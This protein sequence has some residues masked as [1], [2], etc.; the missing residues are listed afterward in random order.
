[1]GNNKLQRIRGRA[2]HPVWL[3]L[4]R[5]GTIGRCLAPLLLTL[6]ITASLPS[7]TPAPLTFAGSAAPLVPLKPPPEGTSIV[8][9]TYRCLHVRSVSLQAALVASFEPDMLHVIVGPEANNPKLESQ[10]N[11]AGGSDVKALATS[12]LTADPGHFAKDLILVGDS[13]TVARGLDL[14]RRLDRQRGQVRLHVKIIDIGLTAL[15]Q[16]GVSYSFGGYGLREIPAAGIVVDKLPLAQLGHLPITVDAT[17]LALEQKG[18]SHTLAEPTITILDHETGFILIGNRLL[19]PKL[20]GYTTAQTPIYDKEEIRIGIYLQ[21]NVVI[22]D[23]GYVVMEVYPQVST[24]TGYLNTNGA[25][26]PQIS[27]REEQTTVRIKDKETLVIGGLISNNE[28]RNLQ[29][30]P[31]LGRIPVFGEL[32]RYRQHNKAQTD[33]VIMITPELLDREEVK[34]PLADGSTRPP[35]SETALRGEMKQ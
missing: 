8:M 23:S 7:Q 29:Q 1:M 34:A 2:V 22:T 6:V 20:T 5:P 19:Y 33:L 25:S 26:Y 16:L 32:F 15:H 11:G 4:P 24:I 10:G 9:E 31:I 18:Q 14:A 30:I 13:K 28:V 3:G 12:Y 27:T 21:V 17:L 35:F